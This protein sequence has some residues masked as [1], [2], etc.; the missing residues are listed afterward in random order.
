ML[1]I[2]CAAYNDHL[3]CNGPSTSHEPCMTLLTLHFTNQREVPIC[4]TRHSEG[5]PRSKQML[6]RP[7]RRAMNTIGVSKLALLSTRLR[8]KSGSE[9]ALNRAKD[10]MKVRVSSDKRLPI[11]PAITTNRQQLLCPES[12]GYR[13]SIRR[14]AI[15]SA[16]HHSGQRLGDLLVSIAS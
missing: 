6:G 10:W 12:S 11:S 2:V 4:A 13:R 5:Q 14:F 3:R 7:H 9:R 8:N 16:T 1:S 15:F